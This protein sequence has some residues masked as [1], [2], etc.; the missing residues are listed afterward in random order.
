MSKYA[1]IEGLSRLVVLFCL[2]LEAG[3]HLSVAELREANI[4]M[5]Q[6]INRRDQKF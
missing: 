3:S 2:S 6:G 4:T 1:S 5:K